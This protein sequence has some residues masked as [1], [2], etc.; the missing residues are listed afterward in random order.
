[1]VSLG[2][3]VPPAL[4]LRIMSR[5]RRLRL[6]Y[7]GPGLAGRRTS[8]AGLCTARHFAH[9]PHRLDAERVRL[10]SGETVL[11]D[12][13]VPYFGNLWFESF[14]AATRAEVEWIRKI[15]LAVVAFLP[16]IDGVVFVADS[17]RHR[18]DANL[19]TLAELLRELRSHGLDPERVP[20]V[21]Q[22]NKRDR[23]D[24]LSFGEM[25]ATLSTPRC[26]HVESIAF[27]GHGTV[28]ALD[29]MV[30]LIEHGDRSAPEA[31]PQIAARG[32]STPSS[33]HRL[34][35]RVITTLT[36]DGEARAGLTTSTER[37]ELELA[38]GV[39]AR[40]WPK[41]A[42][43]WP[44]LE[45]GCYDIDTVERAVAV[46]D[47]GG[48]R[49]ISRDTV[50]ARVRLRHATVVTH[51]LQ[52]NDERLQTSFVMVGLQRAVRA[53]E[54]ANVSHDAYLQVRARGVAVVAQRGPRFEL[55]SHGELAVF[56]VGTMNE[57]H[58]WLGRDEAG[59]VVEVSFV[60]D[61]G[62][63]VLRQLA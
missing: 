58:F 9:P 40:A 31:L 62:A 50:A 18:H 36:Q 24:V 2:D 39:I 19:E 10:S 53:V 11:V 4:D 45:P 34:F 57:S 15:A 54:Q 27:A 38:G 52:A 56:D 5:M 48:I 21:I 43:P 17:W 49:V 32:D 60:G 26:A 23:A 55:A 16:T 37:V 13:M 3:V 33:P 30:A 1:M 7:E 63:A 22:C 12:A 29:R 51:E 20:F 14:T 46:R 41:R 42:E 28:R 6:L 8:L 59:R 25:A 35:E 44:M 47:A 61:E